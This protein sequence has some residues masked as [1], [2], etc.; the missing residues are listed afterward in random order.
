MSDEMLVERAR[1]VADHDV[2]M[3]QET[4]DLLFALADRLEALSAQA[5]AGDGWVM[6]PR[7]PT[8]AMVEAGCA[9]LETNTAREKL[10]LLGAGRDIAH[11]KM[12]FRYAAMLSALPPEG[13]G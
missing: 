7:E 2:R 4:E 6:V 8:M 5:P 11:A 12:R 1:W 10:V 13:E 9:A 3:T